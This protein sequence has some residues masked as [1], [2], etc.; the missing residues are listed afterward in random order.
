MPDPLD[1]FLDAQRPVYADVLQELH[2]GRKT[3]H[4]MWFIFPQL[5]GLGRSQMAVTYAIESLDEARCFIAHPVLGARL[6]ECT[7]AVLA[8][9]GRTAEQVFG[10]IDALKLRSSMTLFHLAE[11]EDPIFVE[12]LDRY[13][14]GA[15]DAATDALLP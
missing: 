4:W 5:S 2:A 10:G 9:R 7:T 13:F 14:A 3:S 1:R 8:I 15:M 11:P 6:R 12:V